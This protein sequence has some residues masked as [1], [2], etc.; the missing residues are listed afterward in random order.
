MSAFGDKLGKHLG[1][2]EANGVGDS[3]VIIHTADGMV[4]AT[5]FSGSTE[6]F[7]LSNGHDEGGEIEA[8]SR[9]LTRPRIPGIGRKRGTAA[10]R[11]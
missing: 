7:S 6:P 4:K 9:T 3:D 11:S 8:R 2:S 5:E 1:R 10:L